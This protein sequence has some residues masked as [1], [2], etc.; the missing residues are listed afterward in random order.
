VSA[1]E[2]GGVLA[3][4]AIATNAVLAGVL[5]LVLVLV[6]GTS[7]Q[8]P[9]P[10]SNAVGY[11]SRF[12][13]P[14]TS[15]EVLLDHGDGQAYAALAQDP[16]LNRPD[17]F[18]EGR[19]QAAYFAQRPVIGYLVWALS[20]GR[21]G[22]IQLAFTIAMVLSAA[23]CGAAATALLQALAGGQDARFA[24]AVLILPGA[25]VSI[26]W[27][28]QEVL[29][30]GFA[31]VGLTL[32][33]K[34]R[35]SPV[36][37]AVAF[38]VAGLTRETMLLVPLVLGAYELLTASTGWAARVRRVVPLAAAAV[39][40]LVWLLVVRA[41]LGTNAAPR[42]TLSLPFAGVAGSI[43]QWGPTEVVVAVLFVG[44]A[45]VALVRRH[46]GILAWLVGAYLGLSVL[47]GSLVWN[48]WEDFARVL[49]P[50]MAFAV[51]SLIPVTSARASRGARLATADR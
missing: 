9:P 39:P 31:L 50:G 29:A 46:E 44:L 26:Y 47:L 51:L 12:S 28:G 8:V 27:F 10:G 48:G 14:R 4:P 3:W 22:N 36:W 43:P 11:V 7:A 49:L 32:W 23:L 45:A 20:L 5:A 37:A 15:F 42:G 30:L 34:R 16:A 17:V 24:I 13:P 6:A 25:F 40:Y 1:P 21:P 2:G 19:G 18:G 38:G 35:P 41:R 33:F